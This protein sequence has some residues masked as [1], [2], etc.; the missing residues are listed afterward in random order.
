MSGNE[1][2][3]GPTYADVIVP[4]P[5]NAAFTYA[6]PPAM[7]AGLQRGSRVL[8]PFGA[9]HLYTGIVELIHHQRP[10]TPDVKE[11]SAVLDPYPILRRPQVEFWH[12]MADYYLCGIGDVMKA[13]LPA[14][15]KVESETAVELAPD[16][17]PDILSALTGAEAEIAALLK[18][19]GKMSSR[20]IRKATG[21]N[22]ES[23]VAQLVE[24]GVLIVSERLVERYRA[25]KQSFVSPTLP[26]GDAGAL[27]SAFALLRRSKAQERMLMTLLEMSRFNRSGEPLADVERSALLERSQGTWTAVQQLVAKGL[28]RVEVRETGRYSLDTSC[29]QAPLPTLSEAQNEALTG[30]R[31]QM[32]DHG[33]VLLHGVTSS[34][35]TEIYIHLIDEVLRLGRQALMLVPEIA[36]TTQLTRRLQRVFGQRVVIYH[37]KFSDNERVDIW[38]RLLHT[39]EPCVVIGARSAIF[40]PFASLG[41]VIVDEEHEPSYKQFD[42]APRYN[43]RDAAIMLAHMHGAKTLLGSATPSVET[44]WKAARSGKYGLVEL[45][46]RY[47][48]VEL[49]AIDIVDMRREHE[50][51]AVDGALAHTTIGLARRTLSEGRQVIF[52]HNRRGYSPRAV[53]RL[54]SYVPRCEHCDVAL[55]YH[56]RIDS[57]M[58]HYC[59]AVYPM[60]RKCPQCGEPSVIVSGFGTERVE[61]AIA[62]EFAEARTLRM[63][64]DTTRARDSYDRI[65][66]TFSQHKAD[67][68][69]GTQ[70]VTKGLDFGDV[71][72]VAVVNAD[73]VIYYPDYRSAERAFNMLEQVAGRAGRRGKPGRVVVQTYTP[74]HPVIGFV[75][76]HDY[77]GF[78]DREIEERRAY[79]YPP[80][81]RMIYIVLR[82]RDEHVLDGQAR[83]Y[84][85]RLRSLFG[86]RVAG[87]EPPGVAR[88]QN[89]YIRRVMLRIEVEASMPRVKEILRELH[90]EL[91]AAGAL[92]GAIIHYD[93]DPA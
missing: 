29:P 3:A 13:A 31:S 2:T 85:D 24:R 11:I 91:N 68:L 72:M 8:V 34:G 38:R 60:P 83:M 89:L 6:V 56:R 50:R 53:C 47:T 84:A 73:N 71:G 21:R 4:V 63:D 43:G 78:F 22:V 62:T 42:P 70:M 36:L 37:S 69:V 27:A 93:V 45:T 20:D 55:T 54:C 79:R 33:V 87:P 28:A 35:K 17:A 7:A 41:L 16:I 32:R 30:V 59:G 5:L 77:A 58:C 86:T 49:P 46:T 75:R 10:A 12:W 48:D 90:A 52:F 40:L 44:Y 64:L 65:I 51:K 61:D 92:R 74:D 23:A 25:V 82:H 66:D 15:L 14:G 1:K 67:I 19:K 81:T 39:S 26:R 88:V 80:F 18:D 57:L 76:A 9:R